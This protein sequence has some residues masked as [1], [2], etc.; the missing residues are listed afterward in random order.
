MSKT[1]LKKK[2]FY[3]SL[4]EYLRTHPEMDI[5]HLHWGSYVQPNSLIRFMA[6]RL[7]D[8][9][10]VNNENSVRKRYNSYSFRQKT[11]CLHHGSNHDL[12]TNYICKIVNDVQLPQPT[13][14]DIQLYARLNNRD[15][16]LPRLNNRD[17]VVADNDDDNDNDDGN[18]QSESSNDNDSS[19]SSNITDYWNVDN[20]QYKIDIAKL[21]IATTWIYNNYR[22]TENAHLTREHI[23]F[24]LRGIGLHDELIN[25]IRFTNQLKEHVLRIITKYKIILDYTNEYTNIVRN[26]N[27]PSPIPS[28]NAID[29]APIPTDNVQNLRRSQRTRRPNILYNDYVL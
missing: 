10:N 26:T 23:L 3:Y 8:N 4:Q 2:I 1:A 20:I 12:R 17:N 5:F 28:P 25:N 14:A 29:D 13:T 19:S 22:V 18:I 11:Q 16:L 15:Q 6:A 27:V 9:L 7:H 24:V 21:I